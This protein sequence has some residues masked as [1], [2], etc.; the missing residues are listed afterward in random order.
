L[1]KATVFCDGASSGNPG[2]SGIGVVIHFE[3]KTYRIS[4]PIGTAT[5]NVAEYTALIHGLET[6]NAMH[7]ESIEVFLDSELLVRQI[8][9][10]YR[11]SNDRLK[12][13]HS[14]VKSLL[15][16][17]KRYSIRHI[18]REENSEADLLAKKAVKKSKKEDVRT[19]LNNHRS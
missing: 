16:S 4:E 8:N 2:E 18:P 15:K 12:G 9:G 6:I 11:V 13:L 5:N 17:F 7:P 1:K 10:I 3:G 19:S 14:R